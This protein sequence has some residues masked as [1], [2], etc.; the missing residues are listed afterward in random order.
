MLESLLQA[1][2]ITLGIILGVAMATVLLGLFG[3][4]DKLLTKAL[5]REKRR[6]S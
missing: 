2:T 5:G 3:R 4:L 6:K 1:F